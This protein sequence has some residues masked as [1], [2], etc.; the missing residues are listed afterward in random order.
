[1]IHYATPRAHMLDMAREMFDLVLA[2]KITSSPSQTF[3]LDDAAEAH[4]M[5]EGR[6]TTR[7]ERIDTV[8]AKN[9]KQDIQGERTW[10][11][12]EQRSDEPGRTRICSAGEQ[13]GL[14]T[15]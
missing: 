2:G 12:M 10:I 11:C 7:G 14:P 13:R 4:R 1:M 5:L 3:P 15:S 6:K 9:T 8:T